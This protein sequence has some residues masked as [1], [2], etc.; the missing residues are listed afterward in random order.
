MQED[1]IGG[2]H[3]GLQ[4]PPP[5]PKDRQSRIPGLSALEHATDFLR[6]GND[7]HQRPWAPSYP[8]YAPTTPAASVPDFTHMTAVERSNMQKTA[9]FKPHIQFMCGPLLRFDNIVDNR[10]VWKGFVMIVSTCPVYHLVISV[11]ISIREY[12][13][14]CW[15]NLRT[16]PVHKISIRPRRSC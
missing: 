11:L 8:S 15:I 5:P 2:F 7:E 16:C 6:S 4:P 14:G 1:F 3:P 13:C 9:R 12:S 10:R